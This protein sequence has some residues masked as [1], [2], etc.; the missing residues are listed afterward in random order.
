MRA[1]I[2]NDRGQVLLGKRARGTGVNQ[3]ALIGGKPDGNETIE[4]TIIREV[5]EE[6][7]LKFTNPILWKEEEGDSATPG[8]FWKVSYF[9]GKAIGNVKLNRNEI[10]EVRYFSLKDLDNLNIGLTHDKVLQEFFSQRR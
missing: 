10:S 4:Q 6:T 3:W 1:I 8:E 9:Y 7:G 5:K 2:L